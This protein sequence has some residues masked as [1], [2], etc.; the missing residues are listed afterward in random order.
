MRGGEYHLLLSSV[1]LNRGPIELGGEKEG[2]I[3][4]WE[5]DYMLQLN[6]SPRTEWACRWG[7]LQTHDPYG[8]H[9]SRDSA[10]GGE[11]VSSTY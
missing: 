9:N 11:H 10:A 7:Q 8:T 5:G 2:G 6:C 1:E 3:I 4:R